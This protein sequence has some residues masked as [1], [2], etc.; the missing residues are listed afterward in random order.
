VFHAQVAC[1]APQVALRPYQIDAIER[2]RGRIEAGCRR[3]LMVAPTGAGKTTIA[4]Q[5]IASAAARGTRALFVAHRRELIN[6]TY[7]RLCAMGIAEAKVGVIMGSDPRR[8]PGA[9]IQVASIATLRARPKPVADLVFVDECHLALAAS[10]RALQEH[11]PNAVHI[12]LTA[13]PYRGDGRGLGAAYDELLVVASPRELIDAGYLVD[14]RVLPV[15]PDEL[16]DLRAVKLKRGDYDERALAAAVD[17]KRLVGNI[18]EHWLAHARGVRT[19]AFAASVNH[20]MHIAARFRD[21]GVPAEH[22]DGT[23]PTAERDAILARLERGETRVVSNA[24]VLQ[25]GWDQPAVKCAILAR[26]TRSTGLYLQQAGRILRPWRDTPALILD[27]AGCALAHGLPQDDRDYSLAGEREVR[28]GGGEAV[29]KAC[30]CGAVLAAAK[31]I[32]PQCGAELVQ[33]EV[34]DEAPAELVELAPATMADK[35]RACL[36]LQEQARKRGLRASWAHRQFKERFGEPPSP[37]VRAGLPTRRARPVGAVLRQALAEGRPLS[38]AC[39]TS[40]SH[41]GALRGGGVPPVSPRLRRHRPRARRRVCRARAPRGADAQLRHRRPPGHLCDSERASVRR[42]AVPDQQG[43]A[44][45]LSRA[46]RGR[47]AVL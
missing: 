18:V 9:P 25:E 6:Q 44:A 37:A 26:P 28:R 43:R 27:H 11:Y 39:S 47:C 7:A 38:W 33:A 5:M 21:A 20:S 3:L 46:S 24:C 19:V 16:P 32:C 2:A 22:L 31:R 23:T 14:P 4:G 35:R 29:T 41:E 45:A 30:A 36:A 42:D 8:R 13:T 10:Y 17:R 1:S 40:R 12:G 15:P 34:H